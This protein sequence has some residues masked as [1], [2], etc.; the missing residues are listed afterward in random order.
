VTGTAG[1]SSTCI[2]WKTSSSG[3]RVSTGS[4]SRRIAPATGAAGPL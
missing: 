1:S 3:A 2:R 4:T